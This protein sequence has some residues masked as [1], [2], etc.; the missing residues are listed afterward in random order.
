MKE[1]PKHLFISLFILFA[2]LFIY[3]VIVAR[4]E[5]TTP[6][7]A[8]R[9]PPFALPARPPRPAAAAS[10]QHSAHARR[11]S[12]TAV[13]RRGAV[14]AAAAAAAM[15]GRLVRALRAFNLES[16][17]HREISKEKPTPAPRHPTA[18]LDALT[19]GCRPRRGGR[20]RS[21]GR[22]DIESGAARGACREL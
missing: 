21:R 8:S 19:G 16:R 5:P 13:R 9:A 20:A 17:A 18:R 1:T 15:G 12:P 2:C 7:Q 10:R 22:G 11:T 4:H 6:A 14:P 3:L